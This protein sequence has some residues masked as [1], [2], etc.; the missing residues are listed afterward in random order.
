MSVLTKDILT[1]VTQGTAGVAAV[2][3]VAAKPGY[4]TTVEVAK[5]TKLT[6][7]QEVIPTSIPVT[8]ADV[9]T[10]VLD[11]TWQT[12]HADDITWRAATYD[13][14]CILVIGCLY[15]D[16]TYTWSSGKKVYKYSKCDIMFFILNLCSNYPLLFDCIPY[17]RGRSGTSN[18]ALAPYAGTGAYE[19]TGGVTLSIGNFPDYTVANTLITDLSPDREDWIAE[20]FYSC[21]LVN[22]NEVLEL[23]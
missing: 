4:Y 7:Q 21:S 16:Q 5:A 3:A 2:S 23:K 12:F 1:T 14:T 18:I 15:E 17:Q 9:S 13:E 11:T 20:D 8:S 19:G 6:K 22:G 10:P